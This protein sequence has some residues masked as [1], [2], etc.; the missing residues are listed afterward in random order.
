M[1]ILLHTRRD[2]REPS[3]YDMDI[4]INNNTMIPVPSVGEKFFFYH[5]QTQMVLIINE[6]TFEMLNYESGTQYHITL[7]GS[8]HL[9]FR[10]QIGETI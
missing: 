5:G 3:A 8:Y 4:I 9:Y 2:S 6:R 7:W 10:G 1:N